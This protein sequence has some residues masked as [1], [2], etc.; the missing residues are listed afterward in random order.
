MRYYIMGDVTDPKAP[1]NEWRTALAWPVPAKRLP[2]SEA[3][4]ATQ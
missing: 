4:G 2:F 1:G 3:P